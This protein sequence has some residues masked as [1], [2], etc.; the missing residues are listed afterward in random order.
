MKLS[1]ILKAMAASGATVDALITVAEAHEAE[2]ERAR[3]EKRR[4]DA[5][6]KRR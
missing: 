3:E 2:E 6:R 4:K 5:E 1:V